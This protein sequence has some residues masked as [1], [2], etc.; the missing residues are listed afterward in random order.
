[1][2]K[3]ATLAVI[4]C[5]SFIWGKN[6]YSQ[7]QY[8]H[9]DLS[10]SFLKQYEQFASE[11]QAVWQ[12]PGM[13]IGIVKNDQAIYTKGF[14]VKELGTK[15]Q[16][17][18][19]TLFEIG[20]ISKSFTA[21]L[22]AIMVD[23][24]KLKWEDPVINH[25]P[26]FLLYDPWVTRAFQ[27]QD[28]LAQRSGLPSH[29]GDAQVYLGATKQKMI[30]NLQYIKPISSFRSQFAYQNSFFLV[31]G[32]VLETVSGR[33]WQEQVKERLF[34]PLGMK[35]SNTTLKDYLAY[36]NATKLHRRSKGEMKKISLD[37]L[38]RDVYTTFGPAGAIN[39]TITDMTQ[40]LKFQINSGTFKDSEIV[41]KTNMERLRKRFI[42]ANKLFDADNYYGL[43]LVIREYSPY[44]IIWHNGGTTGC[45]TIMAFIPEEKIGI[46]ILANAQGTE[47]VQALMLQ[48]FDMYYQK[49]SKNWNDQLFK[50][51][52][53][54]EKEA[55]EQ[56]Q[57]PMNPEA[58][59]ALENYTG[60]YTNSIY[61]KAEI[62]IQQEALRLILGQ[63]QT[64]LKLKPWNH[65][66]FE[67]EWLTLE[68]DGPL[69]L[70][71]VI[72]SE[73]RAEQFSISGFDEG[74]FKRL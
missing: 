5:H 25:L 71:F 15:D 52:L 32:E 35:N 34:A 6:V 33:T 49:F 19:D 14:G 54:A 20:S 47:L 48:F 60:I 64:S 56:N 27:I 12:V 41:T 57:R 62:D 16:V 39:S 7:E 24:E 10:E 8:P 36:P 70:N 61:G 2:L 51:S 30:E 31:A 55:K 72:G 50:Q 63:N 40:W 18:V 1:M 73:G 28:L 3:K 67:I 46:V 9:A 26:N 58:P 44:P 23:E 68:S 37:Y 65:D 17:T 43:G 59:L 38:Y 29:G 21:T 69:L 13:A 4:L 45:N 66:S 22:M 53:I 11:A 42:Y 74:T